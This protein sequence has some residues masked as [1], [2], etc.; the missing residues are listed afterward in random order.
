M[1]HRP[2]LLFDL[3]GTV[4]T[5]KS[6]EYTASVFLKKSFYRWKNTENLRLIDLARLFVESDSKNKL[7]AL[8]RIIK[9]YREY[10]PSLWRRLFF[11]VKFRRTYPKFETHESL[12]P[13]LES[14]LRQFKRKG[15]ILGIVSNTS[16]NRLAYFAKKLQL[17]KYFSVLIS[18]D[19]TPLRKP[20]PYPIYSALLYL[21]KN[22]KI[23]IDK[24]DVYYVGDLPQDIY[25]A[26]SAG[27]NS[28]A[29]LS[30]YGTPE[31]L[32]NSN[33][34]YIIKNYKEILEIEVFKK[35]LLD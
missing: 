15:V 27:I 3:D 12:K 7:K 20:S 10:I 13:E 33:P 26:K 23:S 24:D 32:E 21:K 18:R 17:K 4:I 9:I 29:I 30:G 2:I 19:D 11:F 22:L 25:C 14:L 6:L 34:T 1:S 31:S 35:F 5:Q 28:V 16:G 8:L